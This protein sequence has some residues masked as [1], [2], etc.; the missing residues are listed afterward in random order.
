MNGD[1]YSENQYCAYHL[2]LIKMEE[3]YEV[4]ENAEALFQ[5]AD[6]LMRQ[7]EYQEAAYA[8]KQVLR[9]EPEH[10]NALKE[11]GYCEFMCGNY[12]LC[13]KDNEKAL[14]QN[15]NDSYALA[16]GR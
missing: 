10:I 7:G 1:I 12:E 16:G 4:C 2:A 6:S 13:L 5:M 14:A 3:K 11:K 8:L 15:E 9:L